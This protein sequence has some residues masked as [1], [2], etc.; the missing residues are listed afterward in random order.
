[1]FGVVFFESNYL[2]I[3]MAGTLQPFENAVPKTKIEQMGFGCYPAGY[4]RKVHGPYDP[5]RYYGPKDVALADVKVSDL[6]KWIGRRDK[7]PQAMA[8]CISRNYF[9]WLDKFVVPRKAG[10]TC[11]WQ[12][13]FCLSVFSYLTLY[14]KSLSHHKNRKYHW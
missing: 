3:I 5:A 1:L 8:Q 12:A 14:H 2:A 7:S 13:I 6:A 11:Y 9:R 10:S 4:N